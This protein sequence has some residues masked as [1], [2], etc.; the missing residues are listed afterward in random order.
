MTQGSKVAVGTGATPLCRLDVIDDGGATAVDAV[1]D[2]VDQ[3]LIVLRRGETAHVY[4]N[5][6]PHAGRRL[7]WASGR[8]LV[9]DD[10][11]V[12]AV[13]GASF[14]TETGVCVGGP[15]RGASLREAPV[16]VIDGQVV[17]D[18]PAQTCSE[19]P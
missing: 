13:H 14:Q 12:C 7:D 3:S 2:G 6:C 11:L 15:C 17:L 5:V 4:I 10:I 18:P 8:F 1:V 9:K 16:T 19:S